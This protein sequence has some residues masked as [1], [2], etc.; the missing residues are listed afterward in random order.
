MAL[1]INQCME[2]LKDAYRDLYPIWWIEDKGAY[3]FALL[4]RGVPKDEALINLYAVD[5]EK[6]IIA[7]PIPPTMIYGND[8]LTDK[9]E[10]PHKVSGADQQTLS[11]SAMGSF[12]MHYGVRGMK[13]GV[14]QY[15]NEDGTLTEEGKRHYGIGDSDK[16]GAEKIT[17]SPQ[18]KAKMSLPD[19]IRTRNAEIGVKMLAG[20]DKPLPKEL[21][22]REKTKEGGVDTARV[23]TEVALT[24][25]NPLNAVNFAADGVMAASARAK[26]NKYMSERDSKSNPDPATGLRIKKEGAYTEKEDLA[27]VN[28]GFRNMNTNSKNNC[29]LCTTTYEMRKRGYDVTAQLDSVGYSFADVK[30]WFPKAKFE[31]NTR[32]DANG[33]PLKQKDYVNNTLQSLLKQ[34]NGARGNLII[35]FKEGGSHSIFYEVQNGKV[36]FLD[37]QTNTVYRSGSSLT[38]VSPKPEKLLN[39]T[40]SNAY[41]R[42]DN[43]Q[44]DMKRIKAECVR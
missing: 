31:R 44:P 30:R 10:N 43:V 24:V 6:G 13:W 33:A 19:K 20:L 11:H 23:T 41:A 1:T 37:G 3:L 32:F 21:I 39:M 42:L 29:M 5:P 35:C 18:S 4:Q 9:L 27:A 40:L 12:L 34:G 17:S 14:R 25:L 36:V 26:I 16:H 2:R 28:P 15:Q 7:G 8:E 38:H 22:N